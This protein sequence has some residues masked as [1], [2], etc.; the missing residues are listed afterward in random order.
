VFGGGID[1]CK[2][3]PPLSIRQVSK[4]DVDAKQGLVSNGA[5][6]YVTAL[7]SDDIDDVVGELNQAGKASGGTAIG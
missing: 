5:K 2:G 6:V 1:D 7:P 4:K 3:R